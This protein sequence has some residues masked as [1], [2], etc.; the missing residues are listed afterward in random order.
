MNLLGAPYYNEFPFNVCK[1]DKI[2]DELF[3]EFLNNSE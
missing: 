3:S 1:T 2:L